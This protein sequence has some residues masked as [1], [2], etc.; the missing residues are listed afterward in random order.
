MIAVTAYPILYAV[1]LS[2]QRADLRF[3]DEPEFIGLGNYVTV[4]S[5][6]LWWNDVFHTV[7]ITVVSV[8]P[9][10]RA[11]HAARAGHAPGDLR[12]RPRSAPRR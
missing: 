12:P 4:L 11:R 5:S 6:S 8:T 1:W 7:L 2:L 3:P 9:R 10:A